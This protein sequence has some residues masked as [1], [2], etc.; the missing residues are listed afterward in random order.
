[1]G[2]YTSFPSRNWVCTALQVDVIGEAKES[3]T[4]NVEGGGMDSTGMSVVQWEGNMLRLR[5]KLMSVGYP[6]AFVF[7]GVPVVAIKRRSGDVDFYR[8]PSR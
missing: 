6:Y 2:N 8:V 4:T 5:Q 7:E 3:E 1:M